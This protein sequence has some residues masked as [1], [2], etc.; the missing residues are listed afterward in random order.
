MK[1]VYRI[2]K[3]GFYIEP[4]LIEETDLVPDACVEDRPPDSLYKAQLV[5]GKWIEAMPQAEIDA[6]KNVPQEPSEL[7]KVKKQQADLVFDLMMK[8]VI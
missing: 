7:D 5:D 2:D 1:Q 3:D 4:V 8:G 6:M